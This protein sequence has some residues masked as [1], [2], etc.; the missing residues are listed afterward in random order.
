MSMPLKQAEKQGVHYNAFE[1]ATSKTQRK[2][3]SYHGSQGDENSSSQEVASP[4]CCT[5]PLHPLS[6]SNAGHG[7]DHVAHAG[8]SATLCL[9]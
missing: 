4:G 8:A 9:A 7:P 6:S 1:T 3:S 5:Q 2:T